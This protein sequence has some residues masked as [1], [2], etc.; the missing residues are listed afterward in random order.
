[1]QPERSRHVENCDQVYEIHLKS[2]SIVKLTIVKTRS[3]SAEYV[4]GKS[5]YY[6]VTA[7]HM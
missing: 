2:I 5:E 1:L 4:G 6:S 7:K 3:P